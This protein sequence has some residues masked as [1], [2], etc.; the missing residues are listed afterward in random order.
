MQISGS[1]RQPEIRYMMNLLE[2][3]VLEMLVIILF[4]NSF[5]H[6]L[7]CMRFKR[8]LLL[9]EKNINYKCMKTKCSEN[10]V[11]KRMKWTI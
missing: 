2:E 8:I 10:T 5:Y 6:W 11:S 4:E 1:D 7:F 3:F 9:W